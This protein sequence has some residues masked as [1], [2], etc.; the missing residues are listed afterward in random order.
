MQISKK[1]IPPIPNWRIDK[2]IRYHHEGTKDTKGSDI[3]TL[4]LRELRGF[5]VNIF[6][7]WLNFGCGFAALGLRGEWIEKISSHRAHCNSVGQVIHTEAWT[8]KKFTPVEE[9]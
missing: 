6:F 4:K 2:R 7:F 8:L 1:Y 3:Y 5:V 9:H